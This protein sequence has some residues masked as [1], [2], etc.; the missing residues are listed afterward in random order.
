[1]SKA[2]RWIVKAMCTHVKVCARR[3]H[4]GSVTVL[5]HHKGPNVMRHGGLHFKWLICLCHSNPPCNSLLSIVASHKRKHKVKA[6]RSHLPCTVAVSCLF[7]A[8]FHC[9]CARLQITS[10]LNGSKA[11]TVRSSCPTLHAY[12]FH[13]LPTLWRIWAVWQLRWI[14]KAAVVSIQDRLTSVRIAL[15]TNGNSL[16][17]LQKF[18]EM[19]IIKSTLRSQLN[20]QRLHWSTLYFCAWLKPGN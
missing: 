12:K 18:V 17:N 3:L 2:R 11:W 8:I 7:E 1:M 5:R 15:K 19:H 9:A 10:I 16:H 13:R 14:P 20:S 4:A 6:R